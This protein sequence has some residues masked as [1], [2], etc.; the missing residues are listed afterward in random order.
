[1]K[2]LFVTVGTTLFESLIEAISTPSFLDR[3][4]ASGYTHVTIQYGKGAIPSIGSKEGSDPKSMPSSNIG[5]GTYITSSG[6][7]IQWNVY[8]FKPSLDEDMKN[9][10]LIISHAGAGSIMEGLALCRDR[11]CVMDVD[12]NQDHKGHDPNAICKKLVVVINDLLM[13]NHQTELA[14]ALA[15]RRYL[16]MLT[17]PSLLLN[18]EG[19]QNHD[20]VDLIDDFRPK[21]FEGGNPLS[22]GK[23]LDGFMGF[24]KTA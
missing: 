11:N 8:N 22:F 3:I 15:S 19:N 2:S 7:S 5:S 1:M 21:N 13:D 18:K 17:G 16:M 10:D 20:T 14:E 24:D 4:A 23:L 9:A 6:S 12:E